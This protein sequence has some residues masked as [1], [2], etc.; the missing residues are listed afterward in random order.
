M[1]LPSSGPITIND[2]NIETGRGSGTSTGIDWIKDNTKDNATSLT[3]LYSRAYYQ[4]NVDGACND[5]NCSAPGSTGPDLQCTNCT[6]SGLANC[7][8]C[9]TQPWL[10][11]DCNCACTYNCTQNANVTYNCNCDCNCDCFICACACW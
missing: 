9:D 10:Q 1:T 7:V 2:V 4:R 5:G 8:N 6:L 3:Q 11:G